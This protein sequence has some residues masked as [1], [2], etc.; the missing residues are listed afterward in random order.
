MVESKLGGTQNM[1]ASVAACEARSLSVPP[2]VPMTVIVLLRPPF[3]PKAALVR[4]SQLSALF[5]ASEQALPIAMP[6]CQHGWNWKPGDALASKAPVPFVSRQKPQNTRFWKDSV[7]PLSLVA[8]V[9]VQVIVPVEAS[10][11]GKRSVTLATELDGLGGQSWLV[12]YEV[13]R[14]PVPGVHAIPLLGPPMQV[15]A[16]H[17]GQ[18]C[19]PGMV[20]MGSLA[21]SPVRNISLLSDVVRLRAPVAQLTVP[22]MGVVTVMIVHTLVGGDAG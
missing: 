7:D 11:A 9:P 19:M 22:V 2:G 20:P 1:L 10:A 17:S 15:L 6:F 5:R 14:A 3:G 4:C 13:V 18:G 21:V 12:G 8:T 16:E